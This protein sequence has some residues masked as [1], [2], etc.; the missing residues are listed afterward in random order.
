ML[1]YNLN[2]QLIC[3]D[4][5]VCYFLFLY[6]CLL[7]NNIKLFRLSLKATLNIHTMYI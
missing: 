3:S 7:T 5:N 1:C 4:E 6:V 2:G